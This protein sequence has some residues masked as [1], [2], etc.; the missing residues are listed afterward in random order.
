MRSTTLARKP[1]KPNSLA[2]FVLRPEH[3]QLPTQ[4]VCDAAIAAGFA[5]ASA[6]AVYY[7]RWYYAEHAAA[8]VVPALKTTLVTA[9]A[10]APAK[11]KP[12]TAKPAV[13]D[14]LTRVILKHGVDAAR[15]AIAVIETRSLNL[16]VSA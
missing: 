15:Q 13:E 6:R 5:N 3:T 8:R 2:A 7:A 12:P 11:L 9:P 4:A 1:P 10:P 14:E 16:K